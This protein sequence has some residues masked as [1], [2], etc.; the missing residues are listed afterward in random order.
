MII[1]RRRYARTTQRIL[2]QYY[3][4]QKDQPYFFFE[5]RPSI[6]D[7][8]TCFMED[9]YFIFLFFLTEKETCIVGP[10]MCVPQEKLQHQTS[11]SVSPIPLHIKNYL[12]KYDPAAVI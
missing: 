8:E 6:I 5:N 3:S 12:H 1:N 4:K 7:L 2:S 11:F 9:V 10:K